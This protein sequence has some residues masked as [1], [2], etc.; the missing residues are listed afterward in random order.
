MG[1]GSGFRAWL[2]AVVSTA[3]IG[4]V[5]AAGDPCFSPGSCGEGRPRCG[6]IAR[7]LGAGPRPA[8]A[9]TPL[10]AQS[11]YGTPAYSWGYFG[12]PHA[13]LATQQR[14]YYYD[15]VQWAFRYAD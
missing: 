12:A 15:W 8:A 7:L 14:D 10:R 11:P 1:R 5:A 13:V 2:Y 4:G 3:C 9:A 6:P